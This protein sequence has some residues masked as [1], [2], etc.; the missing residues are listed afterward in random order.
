M[1]YKCAIMR[2]EDAGSRSCLKT[3]RKETK[4]IL[5]LSEKEAVKLLLLVRHYANLLQNSSIPTK[6][7]TI[8]FYENLYDNVGVQIEI[9]K[10]QKEGDEDDG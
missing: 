7:E 5:H 4:M 3:G 8:D 10:R 6:Q 2:M 9:Q 1:V